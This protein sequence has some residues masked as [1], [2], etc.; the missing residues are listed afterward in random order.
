M[1]TPSFNKIVIGEVVNDTPPGPMNTFSAVGDIN[2][3]GLSDVVVGGRNGKIVW[4][5]NPGAGQEWNQ[6]PRSRSAISAATAGLT[7][8]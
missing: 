4:L 3:N 7:Y 8:S 2:G 1:A 5:E 6:H